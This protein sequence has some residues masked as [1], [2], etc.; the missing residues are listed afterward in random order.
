MDFLFA[1][2]F[3]NLAQSRKYIHSKHILFHCKLDHF[4]PSIEAITISTTGKWVPII[5]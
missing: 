5:D 1:I 4:I 2:S 3:S